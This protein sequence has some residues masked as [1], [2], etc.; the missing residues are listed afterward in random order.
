V[1]LASFPPCVAPSYGV[2]LCPRLP[3]P[4]PIGYRTLV[5]P[6]PPAPPPPPYPCPCPSPPAQL[7][8]LGLRILAVFVTLAASVTGMFVPLYLS[9]WGV[10]AVLLESDVFRLLRSLSSGVILSVGLCHTVRSLRRRG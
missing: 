6:N 9:R 4:P 8:S 3:P 10:K 1:W 5:V 2:L 7:S